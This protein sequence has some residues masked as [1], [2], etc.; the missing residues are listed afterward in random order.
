MLMA[1]HLTN[2]GYHVRYRGLIGIEKGAM[3]LRY[4]AS[5]DTVKDMGEVW[6][7]TWSRHLQDLVQINILGVCG[8]LD[9]FV[10]NLYNCSGGPVPS[11]GVCS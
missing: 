2:Q 7:A 8:L 4:W 5:H 3:C 1:N 6:K 10:V 11:P 9:D